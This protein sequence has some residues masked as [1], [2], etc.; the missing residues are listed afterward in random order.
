MKIL[1]ITL[2]IFITTIYDFAAQSGNYKDTLYISGKAVVFFGPSQAEYVSMTD[3]QKD[4]IDEDLYDFYH[5]RAKVGKYLEL[6]EIQEFDTVRPK[7]QIQL[8]G[9]ES[10]TYRRR[11]MGHVVGVIMTDP[12]Q[13]PKVILGVYKNPELIFMFEEYFGL[14]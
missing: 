3:E 6:N 11:R 8:D 10:I 2:I 9:N 12:E 7:I 5:Y 4:T 13:E 14:E 1:S